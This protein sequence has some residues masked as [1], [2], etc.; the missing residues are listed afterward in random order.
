AARDRDSALQP[1]Q[2]GA[3]ELD[4]RTLEVRVSGALVELR[5]LELRLLQVFLE[6]PGQV[7]SRK[8]LLRRGWG[9]SVPTDSRTVDI[10][11]HRLRSALGDQAAAI[12]TI[13]DDGYRLRKDG[14][15]T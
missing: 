11:V 3:I 12:E 8:Q 9:N 13:Y 15:R 1:F 2:C 5:P 7:L 14:R 4:R 6:R 10:T